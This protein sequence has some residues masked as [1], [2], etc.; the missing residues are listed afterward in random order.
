MDQ[1]LITEEGPED[2]EFKR[3]YEPAGSNVRWFNER[4]MELEV[5]NRYRI[6]F[7]TVSEG[8]IFLGDSG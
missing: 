7:I 4:A 8:E 6:C 1:P 5:F 3:V 2:P